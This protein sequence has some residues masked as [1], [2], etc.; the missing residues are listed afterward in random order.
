MQCLHV[1]FQSSCITCWINLCGLLLDEKFSREAETSAIYQ[2]CGI[3]LEVFFNHGPGRACQ[4]NDQGLARRGDL[5]CLRK[6]S[7]IPLA[8][9]TLANHTI[10]NWMIG[11]SA[12]V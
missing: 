12:N 3:K 7:T 4:S 1:V 6:R 8:N 5:S 2:L 10:G 11:S 9:H